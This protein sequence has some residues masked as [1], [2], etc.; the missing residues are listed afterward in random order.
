MTSETSCVR[1]C[2]GRRGSSAEVGPK[3][4]SATVQ[5][6]APAQPQAPARPVQPHGRYMASWRAALAG[7]SLAG[8]GAHRRRLCAR[9]LSANPGCK[10]GYRGVEPRGDK[11]SKGQGGR[12]TKC[13]RALPWV[14]KVYMPRH[15]W[16]VTRCYAHAT[17]LTSPVHLRT[18]LTHI[19]TRAPRCTAP[20]AYA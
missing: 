17:L 14:A 5:P 9:R 19:L 15:R 12:N 7:L 3:K 6:H 13:G 1:S 20:A 4:L 11:G 16:R 18:L 10:S 2:S 8:A